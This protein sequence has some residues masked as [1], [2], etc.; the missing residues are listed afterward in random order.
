MMSFVEVINFVGEREG[1]GSKG[2]GNGPPPE[3]EGGGYVQGVGVTG[4][5]G[6]VIGGLGRLI[7]PN[8]VMAI[9]FRSSSI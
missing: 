8:T 7:Q 1:E 3:N 6:I 2:R 5:S 4:G 9:L